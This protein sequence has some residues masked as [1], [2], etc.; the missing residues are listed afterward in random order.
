MH[1]IERRFCT[2]SLTFRDRA[3][4]D[5]PGIIG[6][7]EG[8]IAL[9]DSDSYDL[10]GFVERIKRGTFKNSLAKNDVVCLFNHEHSQCLGRM[11]AG[12]LELV[13]DDKGLRLVDLKIPDTQAGRD[14]VVNSHFKNIK[15]CSFGFAIISNDVESRDGVILSTLTDV[16][17]HE[18]SVGVTFP[19]YPEASA[20]LRSLVK[21][22]RTVKTARLRAASRLKLLRTKSAR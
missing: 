20:E 13:E 3:D 1:G 11:S 19:A 9:F 17:L 22:Q 15:G 21:F 10:G 4:N 16:D 8:Y 5:L 7:L 6:H 14:L 2:S 18:V 12:T